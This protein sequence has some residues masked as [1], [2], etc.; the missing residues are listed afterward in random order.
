MEAAKRRP[1]GL[2]VQAGPLSGILALL[3]SLEPFPQLSE[4]VSSFLATRCQI[5]ATNFVSEAVY[6]QKGWQPTYD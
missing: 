2:W 1:P 6:K 5:P 4:I 3:S